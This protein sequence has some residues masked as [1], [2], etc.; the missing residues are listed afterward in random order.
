MSSALD[1]VEVLLLDWS[2]SGM[3][4]KRVSDVVAIN[5]GSLGRDVG[6]YLTIAR[7]CE[8]WDMRVL[9]PGGSS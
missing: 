3:L 2:K 7:R 6:H 1:V 8:D 5:R 4:L 9:Q